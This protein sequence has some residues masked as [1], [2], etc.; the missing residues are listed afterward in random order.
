MAKSDFLKRPVSVN[1]I[2]T[3]TTTT[4]ANDAPRILDV[5][6]KTQEFS[7]GIEVDGNVFVCNNESLVRALKVPSQADLGILT[8][9]VGYQ[10][11]NASY[12]SISFSVSAQDT[13]PYGLFFKPDGTKMYILGYTTHSVRQYTLSTPWDLTTLSYDS[14]SFNV[15]S[16]DITP[17]G[18]F[19]KPDGTKMYILGDQ[20]NSIY[21][22]TLS[23]PWDLNTASYDYVLFGVG[24]QDESPFGITF[25]P[26][27]TKMYI[28]GY[29]NQKIY[30]YTLSMPWAL[31]IVSF[32]SINFNVGSQDQSPR[33]ICFNPDGTK[34]FI[35][36]SA[37]SS[38]YQYSLSTPWDLITVSYD[39]VSFSVSAQDSI[40]LGITFKADGTKMYIAGNRYDSV[41]QYSVAAPLIGTLTT[42]VKN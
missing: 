6:L 11:G 37:N 33:G 12:D 34:M 13:T 8:S 28:I 4:I 23:T 20:Y 35:V 22:Y 19:F 36:G 15:G 31:N 30:Q 9:D 21:Q 10:L 26:D 41:Y 14:V 5:T 25:S 18:I 39:Y 7:G 1:K 38:I 16:Q 40:P 24:S 29:T 3:A 42:I 17:R 32:D 27:G 2:T